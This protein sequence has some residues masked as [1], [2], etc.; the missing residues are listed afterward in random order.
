MLKP[1]RAWWRARRRARRRAAI[2]AEVRRQ[3]SRPSAE[4]V[5]VLAPGPVGSLGDEAMLRTVRRVLRE[6]G[7][8]RIGLASFTTDEDWERAGPWTARVAVGDWLSRGDLSQYATFARAVVQYRGFLVL[9]ADVLDGA[10]SEIRSEGRLALASLAAAAGVHTEI[11]GFSYRDQPGP[12]A[13]R[14]LRDLHPDVVLRAR[15]ATSAARVRAHTGRTVHESADLAFLLEPEL[16]SDEGRALAEWM[17]AAR[18]RGDTVLGFN[19]NPSPV[20]GEAEG[21]TRLV[22]A[23]GRALG[24]LLERDPGLVVAGFI[25]DVRSEHG[26]LAALAEVVR[27]LDPWRDRVRTAPPAASAAEIKALAGRTDAVLSGRMHLAI[28]ALGSGVPVAA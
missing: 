12:R 24:A 18:G 21:P 8:S 19:L 14:A 25:H 5:L 1:A 22:D 2:E 13:L 27:R 15:E 6:G 4:G 28:A 17:E 23:Y 7:E 26:E 10:Y 3:G 9:G 11:V 16:A 20:R